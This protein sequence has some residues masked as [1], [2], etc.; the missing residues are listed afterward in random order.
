VYRWAPPPDTAPMR[1]LT[2]MIL[3]R[4]V[5]AV[6]FTSAPAVEELLR[7]AGDDAQALIDALRSDVLAACVGPVTAGPLRSRGVDVLEP[8]RARLGALA[9]ALIDELPRRVPT[10]RISGATVTVRGHAA[11]VDGVVRP[12]PQGPMA[13]FRALA[14]AKGRVLSR[15]ELLATL[16]RGADEHAVEMAVAR[17]RT[18]LGGAQ[19]VQTVTKRGYRLRLD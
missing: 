14:A 16:P 3:A 15:A 7:I 9:H 10:M 1:R 17:L 8:A 11:V 12:L 6:A 13:V 4:H 18:A 2:E 5:D 19:Y